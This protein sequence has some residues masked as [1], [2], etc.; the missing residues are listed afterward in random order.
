MRST[1]RTRCPGTAQGPG[2]D[3]ERGAQVIARAKAFLDEVVPLKRDSWSTITDPEDSGNTFE[4]WRISWSDVGGQSMLFRHNGLH[5]E[6][7]IDRE[8]PIGRDDP[9]G[10]ADVI[11]ES[12]LTTIVDL[13][14]SVAAVDADDKVAA[15]RNWLGLMKG[16]LEAHIREGRSAP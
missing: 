1:G 12:A 8:H 5:I 9:I 7:V 4:R 13:E 3:A 2:Y 11:L 15:Y 16:D 10:M 14:D 6:I